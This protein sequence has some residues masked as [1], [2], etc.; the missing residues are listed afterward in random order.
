MKQGQGTFGA[1]EG[2][3]FARELSGA[4]AE[5]HE[6]RTSAAAGADVAVTAAVAAA[7]TIVAVSTYLR[8]DRSQSITGV[9]WPVLC[10]GD[11]VYRITSRRGE[12]A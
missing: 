9:A 8:L 11:V 2:K 4:A 3:Y 7:T 1:S 10:H 5:I 6:E 12:A